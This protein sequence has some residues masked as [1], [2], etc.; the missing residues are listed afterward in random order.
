MTHPFRF[1]PLLCILLF[2]PFAKAKVQVF[3]LAGQSNM[4]GAGAVNINPNSKNGG[5]SI[6]I[7]FRPPS[8]GMPPQETLDKMLVGARRKDPDATMK[9]IKARVGHFYRLML[10]EVDDT[11]ANLDKYVPDYDGR[12]YKIAGFA[13]HQG[14][15]DGLSHGP[16]AE[17]EENL[18]NIIK[19][20]RREW[21]IPDLPVAIAVSGFGGWKQKIDRRLG[22]IAAQHAI[23]KRREFKG[24]AASVE[25]RGF[26]RSRE[27]SPGGQGYHWNNNAETY[28][29]IGD[30]LGKAMVGLLK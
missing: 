18:A 12:G 25:T 24:T 15:N 17:Y 20:V 19:D 30:G 7:D 13:W 6:F 21:K 22:I 3:I 14:W 1:L 4:E 28:Y 27:E 23:A 8:S 10:S 26:F 29:R 16:V 9:D 2:G 11:L 5:K